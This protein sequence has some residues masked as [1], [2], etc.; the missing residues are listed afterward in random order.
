MRTTAT[1][2]QLEN[3]MDY[4]NKLYDGNVMFRNMEQVTKNRVKFTLRTKD[5]GD[6]K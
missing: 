5:S 6:R 4:V 1:K 3:A 2:Q